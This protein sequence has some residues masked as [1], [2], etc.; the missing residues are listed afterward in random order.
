M[1]LQHKIQRLQFGS[2]LLKLKASLARITVLTLY[3]ALC[4]AEQDHS[5]STDVQRGS[6]QALFGGALGEHHQ[7]RRADGG[8]FVHT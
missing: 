3:S 1:E 8:L 5:G 7:W 6:F 4:P 2:P